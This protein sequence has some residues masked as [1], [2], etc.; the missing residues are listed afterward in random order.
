MV[1]AGRGGA[2]TRAR[3]DL[4]SATPRRAAG[5]RRAAR[6]A[7]PARQLQVTAT[8]PGTWANGVG[9]RIDLPGLRADRRSRSSTWRSGA[10]H[11]RVRRAR[12][13]P[14]ASCRR[15][16]TQRTAS[17]RVLRRAQPVGGRTRTDRP[18]VRTGEAAA[19]TAA[20]EPVAGRR[21]GPAR[22]D[23][24]AGRRRRDRAGLRA[25]PG[26]A[27]SRAD[28]A[29]DRAGRWRRLRG[30]PGPAR[31]GRPPPATD[32]LSSRPGVDA[33][34][35]RR[36]PT[37]PSGARSRRTSPGCWPSD[38]A[39]SRPRPLPADRPGRARLR[40]DR[41]AGP[42]A[43]LR[44]EPGE[45]PGQ[46][47]DRH[48]GRRCR[49]RSRRSRTRPA[50][51]TW[52]GPGSAAAWRSGA[53]ARWTRRRRPLHRASPP[54]APHRPR[55]PAGAS[56]RWSSTRTT[57]CCGSRVGRA[58]S[59]VLMEAFR[60]GALQGDDPGPG[61]PG[62]LRRDHEPCRCRRRRPGRLRDR[63][64]AGDADGVHHAAADPR[65]RRPAGGGGAVTIIPS[66]ED[67]LPRIPVP[68]L[69]RPHRRYLP[70]AQSA[71]ITLIAAGQFS[72]VDRARRRP[73]GARPPRGRPQRLRAPAAGAAQLP[74][75]RAQ[76]RRG[77]RPRAVL[78]V[79]GGTDP[80]DRGPSRR[81]HHPAD[82]GRQSRPSAGSSA[83]GSPP[84]WK[85]PELKASD[86]SVAVESIEIA[87]EGPAPG[88]HSLHRGSAD[89]HHR[90]P[91]GPLRR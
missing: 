26:R 62:A 29:D 68:G 59:G 20:R 36:C 37:R 15:A 18:A 14:A 53:R 23:R 66:L 13:S 44:L 89:D 8:S 71:V 63:P 51:S 22:R 35:S 67:P 81:R 3:L 70:F 50:A 84:R 46:R 41:R 60:S 10:G 82:A 45:H 24:R 38:L 34:R 16:L 6:G 69:P 30:Q 78:L 48:R 2:A 40:R 31:R 12:A 74:A 54:G 75:D 56:S 57:S 27:C 85:G 72:E 49:R 32:A 42:R 1:R 91:P 73:G 58:I 77:P 55:R 25:R 47:R 33:V 11:D 9:V 64:G 86:N 80:V 88:A 61:L 7:C 87:H 28:Q 65:R 83:A 52:S 19:P 39:A 43:G 76:P 21:R 4:G 17:A 79:P 5:P 90:A